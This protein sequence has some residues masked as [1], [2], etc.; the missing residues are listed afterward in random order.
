MD[1]QLLTSSFSS[2][3]NLIKLNV[4]T[5][6]LCCTCL[7]FARTLAYLQHL[8]LLRAHAPCRLRCRA[9]CTTSVSQSLWLHGSGSMSSSLP[10]GRIASYLQGANCANA[11]SWLRDCYSSVS[12]R[13]V[14]RYC[15]DLKFDTTTYLAAQPLRFLLSLTICAKT[16]TSYHE[17]H[18]AA[19]RR[20][21][22]WLAR[23][24]LVLT[25]Q[26]GYDVLLVRL[27]G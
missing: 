14:L 6:Y 9:G 27:Q 16:S 24:C 10:L 18:E 20:A 15:C 13:H 12:I 26:S 23:Y 1:A 19:L 25:V 11:V 3:C 17:P 7:Q 21:S 5:G 2:V 22:G 8:I 4:H